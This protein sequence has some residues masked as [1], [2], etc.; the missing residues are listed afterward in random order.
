MIMRRQLLLALVAAATVVCPAEAQSVHK[1]T[2]MSFR[3]DSSVVFDRLPIFRKPNRYLYTPERAAAIVSVIGEPDVIRQMATLPGVSAGVESSLGLFVR[4]GNSGGSRIE[5]DGVPVYGTS[6]LI[7]LFSS[8]SPDMISLTDFRTGGLDASSGNVTSS[9]MQIRSKGGRL[10]RTGSILSLSPY[11]TSAYVETPM[12]KR[13]SAALRISGRF[14]PLPLLAGVISRKT[15][16]SDTVDGLMHDWTVSY[17]TPAGNRSTLKAIGMF[18]QDKLSVAYE[19]SSALMQNMSGMAKL[20]F[21][22][23]LSDRTEIDVFGYCS[24]TDVLQEQSYNNKSSEASRFS[25][26]SNWVEIGLKSLVSHTFSDTWRLDGGI[27]TRTFMKA[28]SAAAFAEVKFHNPRWDIQAGYRQ[29]IYSYDGWSDA[30]FDAHIKADYMVTRHFGLEATADRMSQYQHILEGLPTGWALNI[31]TPAANTCKPETSRQIYA[32]IFLQRAIDMKLLGTVSFNFNLG[33]YLRKMNNLVSY[34]SSL[35]MFRLTE[36]TWED[37]VECGEGWS[38]GLEL[39]GSMSS[40]RLSANIAYTYSRSNRRFPTINDGNTFPF[41][42]DRPHILSFQEDW[43]TRKRERREQ[44]LGLVLSWSSGNLMTVQKSQYLGITPPYWST[45]MG[46]A[47]AGRL[48][49][50]ILDRVEMSEVNG[51]R[52]QDYFRIDVAYTFKFFRPG[53]THDLTVSVFNVTNRHNPYLIYND[54]GTW[55]QLSIVPIMPSIRWSVKF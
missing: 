4:G 5:Y 12:G 51:H 47:Y 22:V 24:F 25:I 50:N 37:E 13:R 33:G 35:N 38:R 17:E 11:M 29:N 8:F 14:S 20:D 44:H 16:D 53:S 30:G 28:V 10:D 3:M 9:L 52:L 43:M 23:R 1:D 2:V 54:Y 55:M 34:K 26:S 49:D 19:G 32:G 41:K 27:E 21:D 36:N 15:E 48:Q 40:E 18:T 39:S 31:M 7:G 45:A 46:D 42:F 6:H